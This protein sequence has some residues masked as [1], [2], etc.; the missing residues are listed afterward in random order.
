[1]SDIFVKTSG[2]GSTGWRKATNLFIKTSNFG[3]TGWRSALGVWIRTATQW[4]RVWPLSGVFATRTPWIGADSTTAYADRLIN[5]SVV[6]IGSNYYGNNA[7]WD[8]NGWTITSYSYAWV[9]YGG[10]DT[11]VWTSP[12]GTIDSGTG[13]G[14][15]AGGTGQDLLPTTIWTSTN[16]TNLD[17]NYLAFRVTA[18]ASNSVY[19]GLSESSRPIVVRRPPINISRSLS[20]NT[21]QVGTAISYSSSWNIDEA[22]KIET[23][24]TTI[25]WYRNSTSSTSGGTL[26]SSGSYSY[27]PQSADL[28][29]FIY[30]VETTYNSGTDYDFGLV[31]GVEARVVTTSAVSAGLVAPTSVSISSMS[32]FDN[33][34]VNAVIAF[35][36]TG[37]GPFYQLYWTTATSAPTTASYDSASTGSPIADVFSPGSGQ[38][39][40]FYVRSSSQNLGNTNTGGSA[41]AGTYSAYST[42]SAS[43]TYQSPTGTVSVSPGSGTAGTTQYTA[44]ASIS[45]APTPNISYQ[46]QYL[47]QGSTY[48]NIGGATS[49]TYTPPSNYFALGYSSSL[50]CQVVAN[51]GVGTSLTANSTPVSVAAPLTKLSTPTNVVASDNRSDGVNITWTA[52]SGA[53]YYGIWWGGVPGYDSTP[54]FGGPNNPTLITGT[55]YLDTS[56]AVGS[57][58]NYYVQAFRTNNP[59]GTKSDWSAGDSGTRVAATVAPTISSSSIAPS[60]GTAG[61]TTFTASATASGTPTP[62]LSYQWQYF[63]TSFSFVNVPGATSSTYAPPSNFNTLYPNLGFFCLITATN[64]AGS[65]TARPSATLNSPATVTIPGVPGSVTLSG[66]GSV[67]WTASTNSPTSY[68]IEFFTASNGS[69]ANAAPTTA[70][71]Y[72]VTGI[73]SSPYQLVSPYGGTNATWARVRVRARNSAG[74]SSYSGWVPSATTYT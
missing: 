29:S 44:S 40:Y 69:G 52:V 28:G 9:Y 66:S 17:R 60:S 30:A 49:S 58:R 38:T 3:S 55:S 46:W 13:S 11:S 34:S 23:A 25:Q 22:Y 43:Y 73:S 19:N 56:I 54:D 10:Q 37:I 8:A 70:T 71:G 12:L 57:P 64:S 35:S 59:T 21:P 20:T 67:T 24:R 62:T 2:L 15:T 32:R 7:Q 27:T 14:W 50:R 51:N 16:S 41:T 31:T 18:N 4:L 26:L 53:A 1:M 68:E 72:T 63:S 36:G 74:A 65:A 45:G 33:T 5:S 47:D 48:L 42:A 39:F 6:R 61:S